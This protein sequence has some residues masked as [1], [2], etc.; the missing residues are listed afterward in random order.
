MCEISKIVNDEI[1]DVVE[2]AKSH[3]IISFNF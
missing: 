3:P 2:L 1:L